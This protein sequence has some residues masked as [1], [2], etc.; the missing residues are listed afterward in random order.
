M[1]RVLLMAALA[2]ASLAAQAVNVTFRVDMNNYV[3]AY[4][5]VNV[6]G[7]FNGWCGG[8]NPMND[9]NND[10]IYEVTLPLSAGP[11][12]YKFTVDAWTNQENLIAGSPCTMTNSGFTNRFLNVVSDVTL[13]AVCWESCSPCSSAPATKL[14][15]FKV[16]MSDYTGTFSG[17]FV[18]GDFNG[19]C[20]GCNP[21]TNQG[22]GV[23]SVTLPLTSDSIE[24]KFSVDGWTDQEGLNAALP[25][26]KTSFGF[27]NRFAELQGDTTLTQVCWNSCSDCVGIPTTANVTFRVDMRG[28]PGT[29]TTVN[30]N[31]NFNGWCG[32]CWT[33]T[34]ANNDSIYEFSAIIST[35]GVEYKYTVDGW[36]D[37]EN[38]TAGDFCT[39]TTGG[40]TNRYLVATQNTVLP[41]VCWNSCLTCAASA[42]VA[43]TFQ[44]NMSN[45]CAFDSVDV[46][47][48]FNG[49]PNGAG[50]S[51]SDQG[52]GL[53][54]VTLNLAPGFKE[55][56]F[57]KW[58]NGTVVWESISNRSYTV[59]GA[60]SI[61]VVCFNSTTTCVPVPDPSATPGTRYEVSFDWDAVSGVSQYVVEYR[62]ASDNTFT[63]FT[64]GNTKLTR[65]LPGPDAYVY[66]VGY[67]PGSG[68]VY[69][70]DKDLQLAC[71]STEPYISFPKSAQCAGG[72][73]DL[74]ARY[75]RTQGPY[76]V[77]WSNGSTSTNTTY[78]AGTMAWVTVT[79]AY[80][81]EAYDTVTVPQPNGYQYATTLN[82]VVKSGALF[83]V[84][85]LTPTL[86]NG[87]T[88]VGYR[89]GYRVRNS[90][91]PY[92]L[93]PLLPSSSTSYVL[94]L[95]NVCKGNKEIVVYVRYNLG[96]TPATSAASCAA[97]VGHNQGPSPL[98]KD[99]DG[100]IDAIDEAAAS[101]NVYPNPTRNEVFV[102]LN[103]ET[104]TVDIL[105]LNGRVVS[106]QTFVGVAEAR[107]D[108]SSLATGVYAIRAE[109]AGTVQTAR[110]I[111]L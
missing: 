58:V 67:N 6:N 5:T 14:V 15:T 109:V 50:A 43:V 60:V 59:A 47:G 97:V 31:G 78:N 63:Q 68:M 19:W 54:A 17:V 26:T 36:T 98:C 103:G 66:R 13:D 75:G 65:T 34:D 95:T 44:V 61:P 11:I 35:A 29:W 104:A 23:W 110:I 90:T 80:G 7:T 53:Y 105:D 42:P 71:L 22:G 93:S 28:Y 107:L 91:D 20:G 56:K 24:Y 102:G 33:M 77:L 111:K 62:K 64:T 70:C 83:T 87:A 88:I 51:L 45:E 79:D 55:Y 9:A 27:T 38:L 30:L 40:F 106:S 84:N 25:C 49:W 52:G 72:P 39:L 96:G 1:K 12:D 76:T 41:V 100:S 92:T 86:P 32:S 4:T 3:G 99:G 21:M 73:A 46:A 81:C 89:V 74:R 10:G 48:N 37:Q 94:D 82:G 57:R 18:N 16:N 8:C 101:L 69:S 2:F 108:L 85:W